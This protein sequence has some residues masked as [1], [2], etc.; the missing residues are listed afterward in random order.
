MIRVGIAD[1]EDLVREGL[2]ALLLHRQGILVVDAVATAHEAVDLATSGAIDVLLLDV[3]LGPRGGLDAL[4]EIV[5]RPGNEASPARVIVV[6]SHPEEEY[7]VRAVR[8]GAAGYLR[9]ASDTQALVQA[10]KTVAAGGRYLTPRV[11]EL[12][13]DFA[14]NGPGDP[15]DRLSTREHQVFLLLASG[16]SVH[17]IAGD[18]SLSA[19]TVSTYRARI[20]EK[21]GLP[22]TAALIHY[23]A[24]R[25][26][27]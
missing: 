27:G 5:R 4:D 16:R 23:A 3:A 13:A 9:K 7:G 1:D 11:A 15:H 12:L 2:A 21:L 25:D 24:S 6:S 8:A 10:I 17:E 26:L 19:S 14:S 18:L 20:L 22:S